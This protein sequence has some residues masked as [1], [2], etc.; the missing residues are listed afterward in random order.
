MTDSTVY[1]LFVAEACPHCKS[2]EEQLGIEAPTLPLTPMWG[3]RFLVVNLP[4]SGIPTSDEEADILAE[5]DLHDVKAAPTLLITEGDKSKI[6]TDLFQI[7][8]ILK[9]VIEEAK[10]AEAANEGGG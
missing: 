6:V 1:V 9:P 2:L 3:G 7:V 10:C 5:A 4:L 8:S